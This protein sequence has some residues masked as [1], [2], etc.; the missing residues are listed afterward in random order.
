MVTIDVSIVLSVKE[1]EQDV[2]NF[3]YKLGPEVF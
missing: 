3:V 1:Y 2:K